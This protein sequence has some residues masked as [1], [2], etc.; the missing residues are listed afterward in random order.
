[1]RAPLWA[2]CAG[3]R[4]HT[5]CEVVDG[6]TADGGLRKVLQGHIRLALTDHEVYDNQRLEDDG[7]GGVAQ[8]VLQGAKDL[9]DASLAGVGSDQNVLDI[10]ALGGSEL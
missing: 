2:G 5:L 10:L 9:G 8:A 6:Q 1:M 3:R 4:A 7:P